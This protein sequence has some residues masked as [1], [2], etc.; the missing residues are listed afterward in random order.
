MAANGTNNSA[1]ITIALVGLAASLVVPQAYC[2]YGCPTGAVLE[3]VRSHGRADRFNRRDAIAALLLA[4]AT[5][6]FWHRET[7]YSLIHGR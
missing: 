7:I 2:K 3:L 6:L 4:I 1:T 5:V